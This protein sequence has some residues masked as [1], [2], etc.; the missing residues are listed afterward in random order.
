[1]STAVAKQRGSAPTAAPSPPGSVGELIN[2]PGFKAQLAEI[3]PKHVSA[4]RIMRLVT[5]AA[6]KNPKLFKC[7]IESFADCCRRLTSWGLEPDGYHAH[8]VPYGRE[9][10]L[11]LDY[12]GIVQLCYR[13]AAIKSI[14]ADV[15]C[16]GDVFE[17]SLGQV[18]EHIKHEWRRDPAKPD[19]QGKVVG[20]YAVVE[21]AL[22]GAKHEIMTKKEIDAIRARSKAGS[23]GPWVT[24]YAEMA[25]KTVFK[26]C[27]K[28]LPL[29][30]EVVDAYQRDDDR[31]TAIDASRR[32]TAGVQALSERLL[33]GD[34]HADVAP[35][36]REGDTLDA[37]PESVPAAAPDNSRPPSDEELRESQQQMLPDGDGDDSYYTNGG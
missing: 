28:W 17:A 34:A 8:L 33:G 36:L 29:S 25:K 14:H 6:H 31:F 27:S 2:F 9:C 30:A 23:S 12:K 21:F 19:D 35:P 32:P 22:G 20:A 4:D 18:R 37:E 5:N 7:T 26:R 13:S 11:V 10:T 1:M 15:I 24:D 3:V 16:E